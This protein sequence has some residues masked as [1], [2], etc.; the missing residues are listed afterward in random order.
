MRP[1]TDAI[2]RAA[3]H[4]PARVPFLSEFLR[5]RGHIH[6]DRRDPA[7]WRPAI[8]RAAAR[9]AAGEA[10]LVSPEGTRSRDGRLLPFK[11]GAFDLALASRRPIVCVVVRG[12]HAA[13]PA[14]PGA[15]ARARCTSSSPT[16]SPPMISAMTRRC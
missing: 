6:V 16:R 14:A 8:A 1:R 10:V 2:H 4:V 7:Q 12:A 15:C 13:S 11:R 5:T 3:C 9:V